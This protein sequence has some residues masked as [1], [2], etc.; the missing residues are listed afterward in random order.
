MKKNIVIALLLV[1]VV[2]L[3]IKILNPSVVTQ[4]KTG[5]SVSAEQQILDSVSEKTLENEI[6]D[7]VKSPL[8]P[9]FRLRTA[10]SRQKPNA[11]DNALYNDI[12]MDSVQGSEFASDN[13]YKKDNSDT[14][15]SKS[16]NQNDEYSDSQMMQKAPPKTFEHNLSLCE[17][18]KEK[19]STT[20]MGFNMKYSIEILGWIKDK[21][22]LNF[23]ADI[24][25]LD[26]SFEDTLAQTSESFEIFGFAPKVRCEFTKQQ[27]LYVG[28]NILEES[29]SDRKMLKNPEEIDFPDLKDMSF[30]DVKL[31]QIIL[32]DR[33]CK[34]VNADDFV[35]IFQGI[36]EF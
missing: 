17:P 7:A 9:E 22:V 14:K 20:Y 28:D 5:N 27:L 25:G 19:L 6:D 2:I 12:Q 21:C 8:V 34:V 35:K 16:I 29:K 24:L 26:S 18:Y 15:H 3:I 33:A 32:N 11:K 4:R 36:F 23:N 10:E 30:S 31:L 1:I 13:P